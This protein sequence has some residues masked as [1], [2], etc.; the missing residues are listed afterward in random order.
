MR[1]GEQWGRMM[2]YG[3]DIWKVRLGFASSLKKFI[4]K[5]NHLNKFL[6]I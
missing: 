2:K 4:C 6:T 5:D 1:R 3:N